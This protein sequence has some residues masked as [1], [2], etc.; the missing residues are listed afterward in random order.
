MII[1]NIQKFKQSIII[2]K[3]LC[4]LIKIH[5]NYS[6]I[7]RCSKHMQYSYIYGCTII[8][9]LLW[10]IYESKRK[11]HLLKICAPHFDK[12]RAKLLWFASGFV[13]E[14]YCAAFCQMHRDSAKRGVF[15]REKRRNP[16]ITAL[17]KT[18]HFQG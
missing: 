18:V 2:I 13:R 5:N 3:N 1:I 15:S 17:Y 4:T 14:A 12:T 10:Y 11:Q 16:W 6:R 8:I 7:Q 9:L